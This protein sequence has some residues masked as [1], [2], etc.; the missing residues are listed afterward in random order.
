MPRCSGPMPDASLSCAPARTSLYRRDEPVRLLVT[1]PEPDNEHSADVLRA[2]GHVVLLAPA[3]RVEHLAPDLGTGPW[4]A[5]A[6][7][8]ANAARA[9]ARHPCRAELI[10]LPVYVVGQRT[11]AIARAAGFSD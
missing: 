5:L 1:R 3:L 10:P 9:I 8:S 6:L 2:Q 4:S 7:T 11:A